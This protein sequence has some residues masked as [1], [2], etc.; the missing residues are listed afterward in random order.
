MPNLLKDIDFLLYFTQ[1]NPIKDFSNIV[2]EALWSGIPVITDKT[3]DI[4]AYKNYIDITSSEQ[5]INIALDEIETAQ[6]EIS[7]IIHNWSGSARYANKIT[8]N[9]DRYINA[10]LKIYDLI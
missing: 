5:I 6:G 10:N 9:Y 4:K 1:D 2:C 3:N 7:D 8:Y